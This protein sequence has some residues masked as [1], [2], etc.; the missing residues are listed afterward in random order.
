MRVRLGGPSCDGSGVEGAELVAGGSPVD[1]QGGEAALQ[2]DPP[3]GVGLV[4]AGGFE[5]F[6]LGKEVLLGAAEL[7]QARTQC[8]PLLVAGVQGDGG[9]G[10]GEEGGSVGAEDA[11]GEEAADDG[12]DQALAD[13][14]G[15]GV[16]VVPGLLAVLGPVDGAGVGPAGSVPHGYS[17]RPCSRRLRT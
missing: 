13:G 6:D 2:V 17:G 11:L 5:R 9:R 1:A 16:L 12:Q 15:G 7:V 8:S 14:E 4:V 10:G 3:L